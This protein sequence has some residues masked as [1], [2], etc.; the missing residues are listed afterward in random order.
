MT[1][2]VQTCTVSVSLLL[3]PVYCIFTHALF[4]NWTDICATAS[5]VDPWIPPKNGKTH[6]M[7]FKIIWI[8]VYILSC[9]FCIQT[10]STVIC[11]HI[12]PVYIYYYFVFN[13]GGLIQVCF[14]MLIIYAYSFNV[15]RI[16][17]YMS[18][19]LLFTT[20]FPLIIALIVFSWTCLFYVMRIICWII[21][22]LLMSISVFRWY[23]VVCS[24]CP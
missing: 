2:P 20:Y 13:W 9:S 4:S 19:I 16:L 10:S 12:W 18:L 22:W 7:P 21:M 23:P 1:R 5:S 3:N 15:R 11:W 6:R 17:H 8:F 24:Q 14:D